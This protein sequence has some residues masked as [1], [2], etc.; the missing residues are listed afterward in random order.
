M[1]LSIPYN[2]SR[3]DSFGKIISL[4]IERNFVFHFRVYW[5]NGWCLQTD[6]GRYLTRHGRSFFKFTETEASL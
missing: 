4:A 2:N 6:T 3:N 5:R 1:L